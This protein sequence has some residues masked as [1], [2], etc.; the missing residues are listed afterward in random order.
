MRVELGTE[1]VTRDE[2]NVGYVKHLI[3]D[4]LEN[5]VK[6]VVIEQGFIL[7]H[8]VVLPI[9]DLSISRDNRIQMNRL[10]SEVKD[11]PKFHPS[12]YRTPDPP[13]NPETNP[14]LADGVLWPVVNTFPGGV[15]GQGA[16]GALPVFVPPGDEQER[17]PLASVDRGADDLEVG[18]HLIA[19]SKG[20]DVLTITGDKIG[21]VKDV[22]FDAMSGRPI[23]IVVS[24]GFLF[25]ED[26]TLSA[27]KIA[28]AGDGAV[29][30]TITEEEFEKWTTAPSVP[31]V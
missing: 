21:Q 10:A 27:E 6:A 18:R 19:I 12:D 14:F 28:T 24:R 17:V 22:V 9:E 4:P 1:I 30:L 7:T 23:D 16:Y 13:L 8:D 31:F 29:N 20:D 25:K 2:Q 15:P 26:V 5:K 3:M 11:L